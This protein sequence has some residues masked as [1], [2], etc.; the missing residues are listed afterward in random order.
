MLILCFLSQK[1]PHNITQEF[2]D[3]VSNHGNQY[4]CT[5]P[6]LFFCNVIVLLIHLLFTFISVNVCELI[7]L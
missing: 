3:L 7:L 1:N 6:V 5:V 2:Y 4:I